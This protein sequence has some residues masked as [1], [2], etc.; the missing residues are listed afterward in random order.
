MD[1]Y[2]PLSGYE[3]DYFKQCIYV[4][5]IYMLFNIINHAV[6]MSFDWL[7]F[8]DKNNLKKKAF[9]NRF[10]LFIPFPA[11]FQVFKPHDQKLLEWTEQILP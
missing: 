3:T 5:L 4:I 1:A 11:T 9:L 2:I 6:Q 8:W 10:L 7:T